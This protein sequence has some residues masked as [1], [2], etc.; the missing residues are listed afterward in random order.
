M[1]ARKAEICKYAA[2]TKKKAR[3][4]QIIANREFRRNTP[5]KESIAM[6]NPA[7]V[8]SEEEVSRKKARIEQIRANR[9]FRSNTP[10]KESIAMVNP[11]YVESKDEV[12]RCRSSMYT[13]I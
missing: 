10:C 6:V 9:E 12:S 7:Y 11:A 1:R 4:E 5:C 13:K 3:I 2:R 8:E